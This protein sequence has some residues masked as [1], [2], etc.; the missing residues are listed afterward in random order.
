MT[1]G[2]R[3]LAIGLPLLIVGIAITALRACGGS[4]SDVAQTDSDLPSFPQREQAEQYYS[5]TVKGDRLA[6][7]ALDQS[8]AQMRSTEAD[9]GIVAVLEQQRRERARRLEK[10]ER[11]AADLKSR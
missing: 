10:H 6:L 7:Q 2:R 9:E 4:I 3:Q 11:A 8:L 1:L 5:A